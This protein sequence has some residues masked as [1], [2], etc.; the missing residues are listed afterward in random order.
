MNKKKFFLLLK[1]FSLNFILFFWINRNHLENEILYF[2]DVAKMRKNTANLHAYERKVLRG[3]QVRC[4]K[5]LVVMVILE[6][7]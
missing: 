3:C 4:R 7:F 2:C 5:V 1:I 6:N